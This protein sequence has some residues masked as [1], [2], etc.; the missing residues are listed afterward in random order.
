VRV[1]WVGRPHAGVGHAGRDQ[2]RPSVR[3]FRA[4]SRHRTRGPVWPLCSAVVPLGA[5]CRLLLVIDKRQKKKKRV[6]GVLPCV[7]KTCD[8]HDRHC[9]HSTRTCAAAP[10]HAI[11]RVEQHDDGFRRSPTVSIP[12]EGTWWLAWPWALAWCGEWSVVDW[13]PIQCGG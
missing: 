6:L 7:T 2:L 11:A 4:C 12:N 13:W 5:A 9:F 1:G 3:P 10:V 8:Q